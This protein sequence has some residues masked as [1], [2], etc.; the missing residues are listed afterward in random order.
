MPQLRQGT[1]VR[2]VPKPLDGR[3]QAPL[4]PEPPKGPD[5]RERP[6]PPCL[7]VHPLPQGRQGHQGRL[8]RRKAARKGGESEALSTLYG[9]ALQKRHAR[10]RGRSNCHFAARSR[11][12]QATRSG[13]TWAHGDLRTSEKGASPSSIPRRLRGGPSRSH[14]PQPLDGSSARLW[15][16][17]G[18]KSLLRGGALGT[19]PPDRRPHPCLRPHHLWPQVKT[20]DS[21]TSLPLTRRASFLALLLAN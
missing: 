13:G 19:A 10:C 17:R 18:A 1:R 21:P 3:H 14:S 6:P 4:R 8:E 15:R 16:G 5:P 12:Y 2:S 20:R 9:Y 7:R 11:H